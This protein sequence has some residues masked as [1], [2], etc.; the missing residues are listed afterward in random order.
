MGIRSLLN[1]HFKRVKY[2][3]RETPYKDLLEVS[4]RAAKKDERLKNSGKI[5]AF[6]ID[7]KTFSSEPKTYFTT[8]Y[9]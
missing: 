2:L 8:G 5:I 7:G 1:Q 4:S 6:S 3:K 9:I